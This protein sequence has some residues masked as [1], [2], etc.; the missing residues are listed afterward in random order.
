MLESYPPS[1]NYIE[2]W[3]LCNVTVFLPLRLRF[4]S[5]LAS[6]PLSL[7]RRLA[8]IFAIVPYITQIFPERNYTMRA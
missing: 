6:F 3:H 4:P 5:L 7:L 2:D 8:S 1:V